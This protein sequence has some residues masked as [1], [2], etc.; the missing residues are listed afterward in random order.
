MKKHYDPEDPVEMDKWTRSYFNID[1]ESTDAYLI[2]TGYFA[3]TPWGFSRRMTAAL[4]WMKP[5]VTPHTQTIFNELT[6]IVAELSRITSPIQLVEPFGP[7][8]PWT[9]PSIPTTEEVAPQRLKAEL[10]FEQAKAIHRLQPTLDAQVKYK[11]TQSDRA[12]KPR[13]VSEADCQRIA[14]VYWERKEAGTAY[15]VV[16]ELAHRYTVTPATIRSIAERYKPN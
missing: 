9:P 8:K 4:A 12:K 1:G 16:K 14:K 10:L 13:A 11:Q 3:D 15:G 2:R 7:N 5:Q 6:A